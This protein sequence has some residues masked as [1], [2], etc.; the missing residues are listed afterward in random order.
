M[1]SA[2]GFINTQL[3]NNNRL[4]PLAKASF[5]SLITNIIANILD[6]DSIA[7]LETT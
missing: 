5:L 7:K 3:L 6:V 2:V 4:K 1:S